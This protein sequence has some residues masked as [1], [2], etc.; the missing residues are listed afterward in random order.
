M[1]ELARV[2]NEGHAHTMWGERRVLQPFSRA[3]WESAQ[4]TPSAFSLTE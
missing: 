3:I 1:L 2:Q 4:K